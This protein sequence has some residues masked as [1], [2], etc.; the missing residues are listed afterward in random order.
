MNQLFNKSR[1]SFLSAFSTPAEIPR[2]C[3]DNG[4]S[5]CGITDW[6]SVSSV[7]QF[8]VSA[9]KCGIKP[10][11]GVDLSDGPFTLYCFCMNFNGWKNLLKILYKGLAE[12]YSN[13]LVFV[14]NDKSKIEYVPSE[15]VFSLTDVVLH[16]SR[17]IHQD[18]YRYAD[19]I[20]KIGKV[21]GNILHNRIYPLHMLQSRYTQK[22]WDNTQAI[23]DMVEPFSLQSKPMLPKFTWTEGKSENEYLRHLCRQGWK[24]K[25]APRLHMLNQ[26]E[27]VDRINME[28]SVI[29]GA[30][31]EGYFLMV[32][33]Y[34]NW[35]KRENM[36]VGPG[37]G[38]GGGCLV[39]Y[40]TNI[41][42]IDPIQHS[43]LFERFYNAGRNTATKISLPDIDTDFP[44][45]KRKRVID[46]LRTRYGVDNVAHMATF[47]TLKGRGALKEVM[48]YDN[49][50]FN[51]I[52]TLT[53]LI[54][55]ESK[56]SDQLEDT[57]HTSVLSWML[58][59]KP[60]VLQEYV[61][62]TQNGLE[63]DYADYFTQAMKIEGIIK[64]ISQHAS[65]VL[66]TPLSVVEHCPVVDHDGH[67]LAA[68]DMQDLE[69]LGLVKVD[70]LGV[71][72]LDKLEL[73]NT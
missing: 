15:R 24:S 67:I 70:I 57:G 42:A 59:Y 69:S 29:E 63:G 50:P 17:Y 53:K 64:A 18:D 3:V 62:Q 27:Y 8:I 73:V 11:V 54:I 46:Y 48:R 58:E 49:I 55:E 39:S 68:M 33:D 51:E 56:V 66:V 19:M 31:L 9:N 21:Q 71:N 6:H 20:C 44:V 52:N 30:G 60:K 34:V 25:I 40:L 32:Q 22:Q 37:R 65:G 14:T 1:Y 23:V 16:E 28:L 38:S 5:A 35:A 7:N 10:V 4:F 13:D 36:L 26:Q 2:A 61:R 47:S 45:E 43:L 72:C 41:T 12:E